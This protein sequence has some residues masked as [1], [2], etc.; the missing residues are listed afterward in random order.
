[1]AIGIEA[2]V[3][4]LVRAEV[5]VLGTLAVASEIRVAEVMNLMMTDILRFLG[6]SS[7][8]LHNNGDQWR[9]MYKDTTKKLFALYSR[10][11]SLWI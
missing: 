7:S 2:E 10:R 4:E 11:R 5:E 3:L 1:M 8:S 6:W 9:Y